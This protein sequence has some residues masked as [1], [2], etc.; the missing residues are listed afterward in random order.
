MMHTIFVL[1][2][3][4]VVFFNYECSIIVVSIIELTVYTLDGWIFHF[5][6][7]KYGFVFK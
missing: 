7:S 6:V 5:C 4:S 2:C 1:S 3:F